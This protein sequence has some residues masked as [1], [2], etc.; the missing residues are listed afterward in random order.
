MSKTFFI[1]FL[2]PYVLVAYI[3]FDL[4]LSLS[5]VTFAAIL[6]L[7]VSLS[8]LLALNTNTKVYLFL[9][10]FLIL[11]C[12]FGRY[13]GLES[14]ESVLGAFGGLLVYFMCLGS[15]VVSLVVFLIARP[16]RM[17]RLRSK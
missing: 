10:I 15:L 12:L 2:I 8:Y 13:Y 3:I 11:F 1:D 7:P 9:L 14:S 17:F 4:N 6:A 16:I 5:S